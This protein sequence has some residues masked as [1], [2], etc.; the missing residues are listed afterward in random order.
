VGWSLDFNE[1]PVPRETD[2][3]ST[4]CQTYLA[5][6]SLENVHIGRGDGLPAALL[7]AT[8]IVQES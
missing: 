6:Y 8:Q 7:A 5:R 3:M 1:H 2:S 4:G